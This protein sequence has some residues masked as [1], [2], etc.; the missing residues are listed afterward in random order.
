MT[1]PAVLST[2]FPA[3]PLRSE[4]ARPSCMNCGGCFPRL[5]VCA[6]TVC[7]KSCPS[8]LPPWTLIWR[9]AAWPAAPCMKWYPRGRR[10]CRPPSASSRHFWPACSSPSPLVFVLPAYTRRRHGRLSGHGLNALGLDPARLIVIETAHRKDTLWAMAEALRSAAPAAVAGDDRQARS[11]DQP[12]A[13]ARRRRCRPAAVAVAAGADAGSQRR[14]HALAHRHGGSRARPLRAFRAPP[15]A[16]A[17]R[18]LLA[19]DGRANG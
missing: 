4:A 19:T 14:G 3:P 13:A 15:L 8:V 6:E 9:R 2:L 10:L 17:T 11:E 1:E 16:S 5:R 7:A 18:T 12:K